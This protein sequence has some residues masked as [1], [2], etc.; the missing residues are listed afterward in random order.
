MAVAE[1]EYSKQRIAVLK[2]EHNALDV[3]VNRLLRSQIFEDKQLRSLKR[4]KLYLK[5]RMQSLE[6]N[7]AI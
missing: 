3:Y 1:P 7:L 6:R 4:R 2:A 5:D